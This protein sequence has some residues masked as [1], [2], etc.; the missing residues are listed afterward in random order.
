MVGGS[1]EELSVG[2]WSVSR[3]RTCQR[4]GGWWTVTCRWSLVL[5]HALQDSCRSVAV[6]QDSKLQYCKIAIGKLQHC[7]IVSCST[8][9]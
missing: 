2:W 8:A 9:R 3:W 7:K 5:Q 1:V 4:V 6:L